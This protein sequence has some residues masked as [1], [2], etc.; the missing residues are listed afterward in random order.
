[1]LF[2][3]N[4]ELGVLFR[5]NLGM[6]PKFVS[7]VEI[8]VDGIAGPDGKLVVGFKVDVVGLV[9]VH[10]L[11]S[12]TSKPA[13]RIGREELDA[14]AVGEVVGQQGL[15]P[16]V[17]VPPA[18][19][20][21]DLGEVLNRTPAKVRDGFGYYANLGLGMLG[22][23]VDEDCKN[24]EGFPCAGSALDDLL[25]CSHLADSVYSGRVGKSH[26]SLPNRGCSM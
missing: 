9:D 3:S 19:P 15:V 22:C 11:P 20:L 13:L 1:M 21:H 23:F 18:C 6:R 8:N 4:N 2:R 16:A 25:A 10:D 17:S 7:R 26:Q 12:C 5:K 24:S 14:A